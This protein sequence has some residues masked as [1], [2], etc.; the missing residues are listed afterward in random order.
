[1]IKD[2]LGVAVGLSIA[3]EV[4][5]SEDVVSMQAAVCAQTMWKA[6]DT[7][8]SEGCFRSL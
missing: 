4:I 8:I 1:M 7:G 6:L 5:V 3:E 2:F